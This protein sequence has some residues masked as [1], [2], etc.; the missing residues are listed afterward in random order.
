MAKKI[1][2]AAILDP[3]ILTV[4]KGHKHTKISVGCSPRTAEY[5]IF[6][7]FKAYPSKPGAVS[8][9]N[10][11]DGRRLKLVLASF[12]RLKA[13]GLIKV[14]NPIGVPYITCN[15]LEVLAEI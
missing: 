13:S 7:H 9:L 1:D 10:M 2:W 11:P 12:E 8:Y 4:V 15:V 14:G 6:G 5:G 3:M